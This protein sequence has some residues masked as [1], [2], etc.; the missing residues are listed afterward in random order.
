MCLFYSLLT[1]FLL[2]IEQYFSAHYSKKK[3]TES[4]S[5][6]VFLSA[7]RIGKPELIGIILAQL[8]TTWHPSFHCFGFQL[9]KFFV[10]G[11]YGWSSSEPLEAQSICLCFIPGDW[12]I[13]KNKRQVVI[14]MERIILW[15]G[16]TW[17]RKPQ[18]NI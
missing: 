17:V 18:K 15:D 3:G 5:F 16:K 13:V 1:L 6:N 8:W 2:Y 12:K 10:I 7:V 11:H 4:V 14:N 9:L